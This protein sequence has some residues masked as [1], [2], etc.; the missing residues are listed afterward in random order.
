M[1]GEP[2]NRGRDSLD[3]LDGRTGALGGTLSVLGMG[4]A[5]GSMASF[6]CFLLSVL[7]LSV[8]LWCNLGYFPLIY[9]LVFPPKND[10]PF[11]K[12]EGVSHHS[13]TK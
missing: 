9:I 5:N 10:S 13:E 11:P 4:L 7:L 8:R 6:F 1:A 2:G 3:G 12:Q